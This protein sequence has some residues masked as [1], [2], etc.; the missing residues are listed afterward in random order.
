M[1][2]IRLSLM[3]TSTALAAALTM[4]KK[5]ADLRPSPEKDAV[6]MGRFTAKRAS[7]DKTVHVFSFI[8]TITA[9]AHPRHLIIA[10]TVNRLLMLTRWH[11]R[12]SIIPTPQRRPVDTKQNSASARASLP[13]LPE[14]ASFKTLQR[15]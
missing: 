4:S 5:K 10:C 8:A 12:A 11:L 9:L 6:C 7:G 15:C 13:A 1:I 3:H 2:K 14:F